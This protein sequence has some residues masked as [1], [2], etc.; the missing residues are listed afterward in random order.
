MKGGGGYCHPSCHFAISSSLHV[1]F[2]L[3]FTFTMIILPWFD[4]WHHPVKFEIAKI[5]SFPHSEIC[6]IDNTLKWTPMFFIYAFLCRKSSPIGCYSQNLSHCAGIWRNGW[7][8]NWHL[9]SSVLAFC[10]LS[11]SMFLFFSLLNFEFAKLNG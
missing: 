8:D 2:S 6:V 10:F 5:I 3:H 1:R 11:V 4:K 7:L 9:N